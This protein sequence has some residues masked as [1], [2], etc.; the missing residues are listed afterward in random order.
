MQ[1]V[2]VFV[3]CL[4]LWHRINDLHE[5]CSVSGHLNHF[6]TEFTLLLLMMLQTE[7]RLIFISKHIFHYSLKPHLHWVTLNY[8][9]P[10][11]SVQHNIILK[12]T[13][14]IRIC[15]HNSF[16]A[17]LNANGWREGTNFKSFTRSPPGYTRIRD[18]ISV[19][20]NSG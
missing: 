16:F 4:M 13:T 1:T 5:V 17:I 11:L 8:Y 6:K 15:K 20:F 2:F 9:A 7:T 19:M 18:T 12:V 14:E 3:F 10:K